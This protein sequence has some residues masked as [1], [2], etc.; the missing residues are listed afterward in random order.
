MHKALNSR[1]YTA[2]SLDCSEWVES[3]KGPTINKKN[4]TA[5]YV[6]FG[7]H[8]KSLKKICIHKYHY[9]NN[10]GWFYTLVEI[11]ISI[12]QCY[13]DR[14]D[15]VSAWPIHLLLLPLNVITNTPKRKMPI[16]NV[17]N[18]FSYEDS[19]SEIKYYLY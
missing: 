17:K 8:L 5:W 4:W 10:K 18:S 3:E 19:Q 16:R 1:A 6:K 14:N 11:P 9:N 7:I 13:F 15:P 2:I 12:I